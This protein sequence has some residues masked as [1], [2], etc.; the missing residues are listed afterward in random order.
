MGLL[1]VYG[2]PDLQAVTESGSTTTLTITTG[3]H[4]SNQ[5]LET[6]LAWGTS[7]S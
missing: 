3:L 5:F 1:R 7:F 4:N 6:S 2:I